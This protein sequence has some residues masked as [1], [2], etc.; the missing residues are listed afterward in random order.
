MGECEKCGRPKARTREGMWPGNRSL[1]QDVPG[2]GDEMAAY[3]CEVATAAYHRG[4]RAGTPTWQ[5][6]ETAP[7]DNRDV[8]LTNGGDVHCGFLCGAAWS[9]ATGQR[10]YPTHWM[11]LPQP[12]DVDTALAE[13]VKV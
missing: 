1:C 5:P 7:R 6:M 3:E 12:P 13:K 8:L 10:L 4:L 11:P 9:D 2:L